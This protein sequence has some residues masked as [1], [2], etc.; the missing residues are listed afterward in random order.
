M[1]LGELAKRAADFVVYA[2]TSSA[3]A[4]SFWVAVSWLLLLLIR[5]PL[6]WVLCRA[7]GIDDRSVRPDRIEKWV[8]AGRQ[9]GAAA[10][11]GTDA[12]PHC[13][14]RPEHASDPRMQLPTSPAR[15]RPDCWAGA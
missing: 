10:P 12:K 13:R 7:L 6:I 8:H 14:R 11:R 1:D 2:G 5:R 9:D 3:L 4:F 15:P